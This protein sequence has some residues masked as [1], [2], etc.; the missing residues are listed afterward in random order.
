MS[1]KVLTI[2]GASKSQSL[3]LPESLIGLKVNN[4]LLKYVVDWQL[5]RSKK[6]IAKTNKNLH[7]GN[8]KSYS[9]K[10]N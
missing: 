10:L 3:K 4:R 7:K 6:R 5:N 2:D 9:K 8:F 1:I